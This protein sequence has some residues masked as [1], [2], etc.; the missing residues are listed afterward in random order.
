MPF[1]LAN[2][3]LAGLR[4]GNITQQPVDRTAVAQPGIF[5]PAASAGNNPYSGLQNQKRLFSGIVPGA[6]ASTTP[7]PSMMRGGR[8]SYQDDSFA[9]SQSFYDKLRS[10]NDPANRPARTAYEQAVQDSPQ[11]QD[12]APSKWRRLAAA[13]GGAAGGFAAGPAQGLGVA[14]NINT[15]PYRT[16]LDSYEQRI[17]GLGEAANLEASDIDSERQNFIAATEYGNTL[18]NRNFERAYKGRELDVKEEEAWN[19]YQ[20]DLADIQVKIAQA[21]NAAE[22]NRLIGVGH[23]ITQNYNNAR[24]GVDRTNAQTN[25][26]NA[27]TQRGQLGVGQK[28]AESGRITAEAAKTRANKYRPP[29]SRPILEPDAAW[30]LALEQLYS[31]PQFND[32]IEFDKT[33]GSYQIKQGAFAD[34]TLKRARRLADA[35]SKGIELSGFGTFDD[36]SD[37][38]AGDDFDD[39]DIGTPRLR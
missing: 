32:R 29:Q 34:D 3:P 27:Q 17:S 1:N 31:D 37:V 10:F 39:I 19:K 5:N 26:Y 24:I 2:N 11:G 16:A 7:S 35:I 4:L 9:Q 22:R 38:E 18:S 14:E 13:L 33:Y 20:A 23:E 30:D 36:G 15:A 8:P 6:G 12:Y 28:N 21:N 25:Q